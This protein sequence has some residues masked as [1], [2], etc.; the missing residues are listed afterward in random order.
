MESG[1]EEVFKTMKN[2]LNTEQ[3]MGEVIRDMIKE[4]LKDIIKQKLNENPEIKKMIK[5]AISELLEA[6]LNEYVAMVKLVK[7]SADMGL[8]TLPD[9]IKKDLS[10]DLETFI[11]KSIENILVEK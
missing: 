1:P 4:E 3:I 5:K 11:Q 8:T 10:N 6:K 9:K 7:Y 2:I